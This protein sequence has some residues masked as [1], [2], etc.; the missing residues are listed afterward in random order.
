MDDGGLVRCGLWFVVSLVVIRARRRILILGGWCWINVCVGIWVCIE[1]IVYYWCSGWCLSVSGWRCE[2]LIFIFWCSR[3]FCSFLLRVLD[4]RFFYIVLIVEWNESKWWCVLLVSFDWVW[5]FE[6]D[7]ECDCWL[8]VWTFRWR[9]SASCEFRSVDWWMMVMSMCNWICVLSWNILLGF[10]CV[11]WKDC[12][13]I[14]RWVLFVCR[15]RL[16]VNSIR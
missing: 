6:I 10:C 3:L 1:Y 11:G 5:C 12:C 8:F 7:W 2:W 4:C 13:I 9:A 15:R 14:C 16:T